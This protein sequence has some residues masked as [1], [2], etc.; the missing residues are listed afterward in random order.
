M[1]LNE[2]ETMNQH[3]FA[4]HSHSGLQ[5][6]VPVSRNISNMGVTTTYCVN[7]AST[8][9]ALNPNVNVSSGFSTI[10]VTTTYSQPY[11]AQGHFSQPLSGYGAFS[12]PQHL[13]SA[14]LGSTISGIGYVPTHAFK[15]SSGMVQPGID[16][17]ETSS[18]LVVHA[19]AP[20]WDQN[21]LRLSVTEDSLSISG[22][23]WFSNRPLALSRSVALPT[24]IRAEAVEANLQSG[25][26][27]IRLPKA[28]KTS[29]RKNVTT[30][31]N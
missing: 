27:E 30:S 29:R 24:S 21:S 28:D 13:I 23:A 18:D 10:P 8:I 7:P 2:E 5:Q 14:D 16:I 15:N 17:S 1:K 4:S 9:H 19:Y 20:N 3:P 6:F 26:L 25:V 22:T 12:S 31:E 11:V